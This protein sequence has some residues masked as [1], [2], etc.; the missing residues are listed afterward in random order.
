VKRAN[1]QGL[2]IVWGKPH[3]SHR[4]QLMAHLLGLDVAH[5]FTDARRSIF[6]AGR[7]YV[8]QAF[9]TIRL[10]NDKQPRLVFVQNPPIFAALCVYLWSR[11]RRTGTQFVIDSHTDALLAPWWRWLSPLHRF[12]SK[13]AV[14]TL[15]TNE[16]LRRLVSDWG[17][18]AHI[19]GDPPTTFPHR[20][21]MALAD[22]AFT[23]AL[24]STASY[25]EP[26]TPVLEAARQ[27]PAVHFYITGNWAKRRPDILAQTQGDENIHFTGYMPDEQFYGL[28]EAVDAVMCLTTQNHTIQSGASEALWLGRPIIISDW[29]LLREYFYQGAVFVDNS[30]AGIEQA[31]LTARQNHRALETEIIQLQG[32]RRREWQQKAAEILALVN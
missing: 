26:I 2:F 16:H 18:T 24:V 30:A 22:H 8:M 9:K 29:P 10:L 6:N 5:V 17:V 31:V 27:L 19:L 32:E 25:D 14:T 7:R 28:L 12:L 15:V 4:S 11:F 13:R 3:G 1:L 21:K 20:K 23:V